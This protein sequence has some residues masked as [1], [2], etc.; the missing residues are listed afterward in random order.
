[1]RLIFK[2]V[3]ILIVSASYL[4][5][6]PVVDWSKQF[7]TGP[8]RSISISQNIVTLFL[9]SRHSLLAQEFSKIC[10]RYGYLHASD[11]RHMTLNHVL[12]QMIP[13]MH[14]THPDQ[15]A[16]HPDTLQTI[17]YDIG[18]PDTMDTLAE[19][20]HV[21][22]DHL[23]SIGHTAIAFTSAFLFLLYAWGAWYFSYHL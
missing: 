21:Y 12:P 3:L 14:L 13:H 7:E 19:Y 8:V 18:F 16:L 23:L 2:I 5:A 20:R 6:F 22:E 4:N 9:R 15:G 11:E 17:L 10:E 1:V